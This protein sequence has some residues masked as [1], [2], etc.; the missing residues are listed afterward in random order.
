MNTLPT[1]AQK[2]QTEIRKQC[3]QT[4]CEH[5]RNMPTIWLPYKCAVVIRLVK[6]ELR[7]ALSDHKVTAL[8][9]YLLHLVIL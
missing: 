4:G 8:R 5:R 9:S 6:T 7:D 3:H 2:T 1:I